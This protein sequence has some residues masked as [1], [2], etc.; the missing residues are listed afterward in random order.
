[1]KKYF[2]FSIILS[3]LYSC[4][5]DVPTTENPVSSEWA[6]PQ[7]EIFD[8]GP[9]KDGI[10]S[11]DNPQFGDFTDLSF[12]RDDDL[13]IGVQVGDIIKGY[14]HPILDWHEIVNDK[15]G[16]E[17]Y[18]LTYCPLT[19]TA[20]S[21]DRN[22]NG[23]E[24]EFGVSGL[25]YNTNLMPYDR[26]TNSTWSQQRNDCVNGPLIGKIIE[27]KPLIET[28]FATFRSAF[29]NAEIMTNDT[30]F[31][32]NYGS[33]PYGDYRSNNS[34]ILFPISINDSRLPVKERVLGVFVNGDVKAYTFGNSTTIEALND[35]FNGSNIVLLRSTEEN[36][37]IAFENPNQLVFEG[38]EGQLPFIIKDESGVSYDLFGRS[39]EEGA[40]DLKITESFIG[41]WFSWG[42]FYPDLEIFEN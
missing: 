36:I 22:I 41:Y 6:I 9:G 29:P 10:P 33:Y 8:G 7:D 25:L 13:I 16:G 19:G 32:R 34:R 42:T 4:S 30:G 21:W 28:N 11:V 3:G 35:E 14:P 26:K 39:S 20:I 18:A 27:T 38:L 1:M 2:W 40:P 24:T 31:G 15:I 12:M 17:A 23:E 37:L 5:T